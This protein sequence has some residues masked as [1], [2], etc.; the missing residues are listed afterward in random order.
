MARKT[1]W[2]ASAVQ[3]DLPSSGAQAL[4]D[5][6]Q[7]AVTRR[8]ANDPGLT[9]MRILGKLVVLNETSETSAALG[10]YTLGIGVY[11]EL[12]D[13]D[14]FPSLCTHEGDWLW[15][16]AAGFK[17]AG[18]GLTEVTPEIARNIDVDARSKR[19]LQRTSDLLFLVGQLC[20]ISVDLTILGRL[21][22]LWALP[23]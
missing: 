14:D 12:T 19:V 16:S 1:F 13:I 10:S 23:D 3:F 8:L 22:I 11:T 4:V 18:T 21:S 17:G 15:Y 9:V 6:S 2:T 5:L 20:D 7:Q